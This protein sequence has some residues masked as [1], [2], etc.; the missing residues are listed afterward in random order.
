[1]T[2]FIVVTLVSSGAIVVNPAD[3]SRYHEVDK[4]DYKRRMEGDDLSG[5][6]TAI[7]LRSL[8]NKALVVK[9]SVEEINEQIAEVSRLWRKF[10]DE[11]PA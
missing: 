3:I 4:E 11:T 8:S 7:W 10:L 5:N 9:E 2:R 6:P 1:M